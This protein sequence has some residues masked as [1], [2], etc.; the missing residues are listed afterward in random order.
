MN[1]AFLGKRRYRLG[2]L[3]RAM[4][5]HIST[6]VRWTQRG[7]RGRV[8]KSYLLGGRRYI[9]RKDVLSFLQAINEKEVGNEPRPSPRREAEMRRVDEELDRAGI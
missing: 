6:V 4:D 9:D 1:A 3:A 5:K 7:V 8:L 2:E